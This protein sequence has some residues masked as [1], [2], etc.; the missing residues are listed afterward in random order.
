M[1]LSAGLP[2]WLIKNG[3]PFDYPKLEKSTKTEVTI[4]GGGISGALIAY[5]LINAGISCLVA[6]S[7]SIGLGS[8]C[9]STSLLQYEIDTS[10][11][12]LA[13]KVGYRNAVRSYELC[14]QA[15][16]KLQQIAGKINFPD[17]QHKKSL[18]YAAY[19]KDKAFIKKEF[20]IR[21]EN[22]FSVRWLDENS[23][24]KLYGFI[25]PGAILSEQGGQTDAYTFAHAL[26]QYSIKKGLRVYDRTKI[27]SIKHAKNGI[28][29]KTENGSVIKTKKLVYATG[30][31]VVEF[32]DKKL[33]DLKSTYAIISE[34]I[35]G[36]GNFWKD[37]SLIWNTADPYLYLRTT[38]DKRIIVGGRDEAF[39]HPAHRDN[40]I[41]KKTTQLVNDFNKIF[42][43][44]SFN[45]EFSWAGTF[46]STADGLP[47][48]GAYKKRP[49]SFFSLGFGGNG[50]TFSLIAA[51]IITDLIRDK[52]NKDA[53]LFSFERV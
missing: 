44:I 25:A 35:N 39:T 48:I 20:A 24:H 41:K 47:F 43:G 37:N 29:L 50:I 49:D 21:K 13:D 9:S 46:G 26:H 16:D 19:K 28:I 51:G 27:V 6:D 36:T 18:Y 15:I 10:L 8:T 1:N 5:H 3:L 32:I 31:E 30:Y 2:F 42:P 53:A 33:V 34:Q 14:S 17:I 23:L 45:P 4:L 11:H 52:K 7:R 12:E 40:L 22:G 38:N